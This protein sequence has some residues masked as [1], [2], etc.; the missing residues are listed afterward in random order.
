MSMTSLLA[1]MTV[2]SDVRAGLQ[3][4]TSVRQTAEVRLRRLKA[5]LTRRWHSSPATFGFRMAWA[6]WRN[7]LA[8]IQSDHSIVGD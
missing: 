7:A 6:R 1:A 4:V 2:V 5:S 3:R 8:A